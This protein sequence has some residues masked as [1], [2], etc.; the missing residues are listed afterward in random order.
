MSKIFKRHCLKSIDP[1][2]SI[3]FFFRKRNQR[4]AIKQ[5]S[6]RTS[7]SSS[8]CKL[9]RHT[10]AFQ[11]DSVLSNNRSNALCLCLP[12]GPAQ[13]AVLR[14]SLSLN[15]WYPPAIRLEKARFLP[16]VNYI[17]RRLCMLFIKGAKDH[18][19]LHT[20]PPQWHQGHF[21]IPIR[22]RLRS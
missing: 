19:S 21:P 13:K 4:K 7:S 11:V 5:V 1:I 14:T 8:E 12:P 22:G 17:Q 9:F 20:S 2:Q 6:C 3:H 16:K 10:T 18:V 15:S